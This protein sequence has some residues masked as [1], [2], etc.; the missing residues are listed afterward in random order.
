MKQ[1]KKFR[2]AVRKIYK[3]NLRF[4]HKS[5]SVARNIFREISQRCKA[6]VKKNKAGN[7][8]FKA[9]PAIRQRRF[10]FFRVFLK[11]HRTSLFD[12]HEFPAD[13]VFSNFDKLSEFTDPM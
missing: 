10:L 8:F 9:S 2:L 1:A 12:F 4:E 7:S 3:S 6:G 5:R 13:C 11:F